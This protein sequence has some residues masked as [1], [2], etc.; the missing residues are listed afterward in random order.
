M[1]ARSKSPIRTRDERDEINFA[2]VG[3]INSDYRVIP[4]TLESANGKLTSHY[5]AMLTE[6]YIEVLLV[7]E[8]LADHIW[9]AWNVGEIDDLGTSLMWLFIVQRPLYPR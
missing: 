8:E 9:E 3:G 6:I 7:G 5:A 4:K 1:S 2:M